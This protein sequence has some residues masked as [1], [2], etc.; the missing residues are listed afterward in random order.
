MAEVSLTVLTADFGA[1]HAVAVIGM[2]SHGIDIYLGVKARPAAAG[3]E[4]GCGVKQG[5]LTTDTAIDAIIGVINIAAGKRWL[6]AGLAGNKKLLFS[7]LFSPLRIGF[8]QFVR[9]GLAQLPVCSAI[10]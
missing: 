4:F 3:I 10:L 6:S 9:H 2:M 5:L 8:N 1:I 7:E